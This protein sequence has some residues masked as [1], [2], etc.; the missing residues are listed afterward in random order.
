MVFPYDYI[1]DFGY[2]F[3]FKGSRLRSRRMGGE[4]LFSLLTLGDFSSG[5]QCVRYPIVFL[6][7]T[8]RKLPVQEK[9]ITAP[10]FC[11]ISYG[12]LKPEFI[13]KWNS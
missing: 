7:C 1:S 12:G 6:S 11:R 5:L 8:V 3:I 4:I 2:W 10:G 13:S 9:R